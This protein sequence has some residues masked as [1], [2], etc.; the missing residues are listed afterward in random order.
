[1]FIFSYYRVANKKIAQFSRVFQGFFYIISR[2]FPGIFALI[3]DPSFMSID[4]HNNIIRTIILQT[5][6][7]RTVFYRCAWNGDILKFLQG[8][9]YF[10]G[11]SRVFSR[12]GLT[13]Q[14]FPGVSRVSRDGWPPCIMCNERDYICTR[15]LIHSRWRVYITNIIPRSEMK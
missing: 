8:S 11:A 9:W 15:Y 6:M 14:G 12:G 5:D 7:D 3:F 13:F 4:N 10:P 1:M 2:D